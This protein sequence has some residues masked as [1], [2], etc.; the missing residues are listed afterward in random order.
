MDKTII[1]VPGLFG[2]L[3]K[4]SYMPLAKTFGAKDFLLFRAGADW[5]PEAIA[6]DISNISG[7]KI[8]ICLSCGALIGNLLAGHPGTEV[9][10]MCPCLGRDFLRNKVIRRLSPFLRIIS[11]VFMAITKP[12]AW[13]R[14]YPL[15]GG[16]KPDG[17]HLSLYA[18]I[19]QFAYILSKTP[20]I[21]PVS[22]VVYSLGDNSIDPNSVLAAFP[23][24]VSAWTVDH[25]SP[26]HI[27]L[28]SEGSQ[29]GH[30][31]TDQSDKPG[32]DAEAYIEA[33]RKILSKRP[34]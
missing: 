16:T 28:R 29:F 2:G 27:N 32:R 21:K 7:H 23:D 14:W 15:Y 10:Y 18:I 5:N 22:G 25:N 8:V 17:W 20:L 11:L 12:L 31:G 24:A 9:F 19:K 1:I 34:L 4:K 33:F 26:A 30:I 6:M 3:S 13:H